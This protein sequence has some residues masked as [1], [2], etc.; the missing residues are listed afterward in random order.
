MTN[1]ARRGSEEARERLLAAGWEAQVRGALLVW[2]RPSGRGGWYSQ[3]VALELLEFLEE[4][5][6]WGEGKQ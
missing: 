1:H 5:K 3:E 2:R 4:E 6:K